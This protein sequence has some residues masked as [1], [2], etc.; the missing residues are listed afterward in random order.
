MSAA[1]VLALVCI[2][3][4]A[5][6]VEAV[7]GFGSTVLS[8]SL[9]SA[10]VPL[11]TL[12]P[13]L[14][15]LNLL[16]SANILWRDWST[17]NRRLLWRRILPWV[18]LGLPLGFAAFRWWQPDLMRAVFGLFVV[19]F[20]L[21]EAVRMLRRATGGPRIPLGPWSSAGWLV[22]GGVMQGAFASGGPMIVYFAQRNLPDKSS[23][24]STLAAAWWLLNA[25]LIAG[26]AATGAYTVEVLRL[27]LVLLPGVLAGIVLGER[28]HHRIPETSFRAVVV[29]LLTA[30][31]LAVLIDAL[32]ALFGEG[33]SG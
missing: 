5:Y 20:A 1:G 30:A 31:G 11:G 27:T 4:G 6:A 28:L 9:G 33:I 23:F 17:V 32:P 16:L 13:A 25:V 26:H 3:G 29:L 15:P 7:V 12:V 2:V 10:W 24:R 22:A 14:L 18:A 21:L 8:L 19:G